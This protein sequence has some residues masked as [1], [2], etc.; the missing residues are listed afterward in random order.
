MCRSRSRCL[1]LCR[2]IY[3][4]TVEVLYWH[5]VCKGL[6]VDFI[7]FHGRVFEVLESSRIGELSLTR[8]VI[9]HIRCNSS[10]VVYRALNRP[11]VL[12][13]IDGTKKSFRLSLLAFDQRFHLSAM[14]RYFLLLLA[15]D[16]H[17][18]ISD[19]IPR[20]G[21]CSCHSIQCCRLY[22]L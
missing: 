17:C 15:Y 1:P 6:R 21:S 11:F 22:R 9:H 14:S 20:G 7:P 3:S 16:T 10:K 19:Q 4:K 2:Q 8:S 12:S 13:Q 18:K 5:T